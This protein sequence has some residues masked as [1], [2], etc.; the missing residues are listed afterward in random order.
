VSRNGKRR[1]HGPEIHVG[2]ISGL[3][4]ITEEQKRAICLALSRID[5]DDGGGRPVLHHGCGPGADVVAHL[6]VRRRGGWLVHGH[7]ASDVIASHGIVNILDVRN[8]SEDRGRRDASI[9]AASSIVLVVLP[10]PR[11]SPLPGQPDL[12][13]LIK[14][15]ESAGKRIIYIQETAGRE[16]SP[17]AQGAALKSPAGATTPS[18]PGNGAAGPPARENGAPA[19]TSDHG[20]RRSTTPAAVEGKRVVSQILDEWEQIAVRTLGARAEVHDDG[21]PVVVILMVGGKAVDQFAV[22]EGRDKALKYVRAFDEKAK[23]HRVHAPELLVDEW[24]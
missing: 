7:P 12:P 4:K 17:A 11:Y 10:C 9:L 2:L 3:A 8:K 22:P 20:S 6:F 23:R 15:A 21:T 5:S 18:L 1:R 13:T 14:A 16:R 24:R 19:P